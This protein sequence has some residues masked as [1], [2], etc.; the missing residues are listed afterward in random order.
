MDIEHIENEAAD[1]EAD[2]EALEADAEETERH[3]EDI[4]KTIERVSGDI[5]IVEALGENRRHVEDAEQEIQERRSGLA[6]ELSSLSSQLESQFQT[7]EADR[8][9]LSDLAS[10]GEDVSESM[11]L[12]DEKQ[13]WLESC[14]EQLQQLGN[15]LDVALEAYDLGDW[16][17][18]DA[19]ENIEADSVGIDESH[20]SEVEGHGAEKGH[21]ASTSSATSAPGLDDADAPTPMQALSAYMSAHNYSKDD[22]DIYSNDPEWQ[23]LT[24]AA[25]PDYHP[26]VDAELDYE[27]KLAWVRKACP[28]AAEPEVERIVGALVYYF[29][30]G[31]KDIHWDDQAKVQE[32]RDIL[33]V[34]DGGNVPIYQGAIYRGLSFDSKQDLM[35]ALAKDPGS[36]HEPAISSFSSDFDV[37]KSFA[38]HRAWGIVFTCD[39]NKTAIP[40]THMSPLTYEHEVLSPGGLRNKGWSVDVASIRVDREQRLVF[41][42]IQEK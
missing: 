9:V 19:P 33:K 32:T 24:K 39:N 30:D 23:K 5:A 2:V 35:K 20:E 34:F 36:W 40:V 8:S 37:A 25:F 41:A 31:Y 11:A 12:L 3:K 22:Y 28:Y 42:D 6:E 26:V 21:G 1:L 16:T 18:S 38:Q 4:D 10:I 13:T 7:L 17:T 27:H 15:R 14:Q 29:G